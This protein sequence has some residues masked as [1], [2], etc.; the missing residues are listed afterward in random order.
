[1]KNANTNKPNNTENKNFFAKVGGWFAKTGKANKPNNTENKNFFAKVVGWFSKTG[2]AIGKY[3]KEVYGEVKKL[4]WPSRK[5]LISYTLAVIAFVALLAVIMWILD[6][7]FSEG[8]K[9]LA[10]IGQ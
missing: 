1:M 7:G 10:S 9:A 2:K 5:E 3:F 6:L 8:V 4:S